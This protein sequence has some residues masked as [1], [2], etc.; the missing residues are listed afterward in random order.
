VTLSYLPS[1]LFVLALVTVVPL[2][3]AA[4][5]RM[6]LDDDRLRVPRA[7]LYRDVVASQWILAVIALAVLIPVV[8][9]LA[10]TGLSA[11]AGVGFATV[12]LLLTV[13][14]VLEGSG[15]RPRL[16]LRE[17]G[18]SLARVSFLL[19]RTRAERWWW[20][21]LSVTAGVCEE[22]VFRGFLL[23]YLATHAPQIGITGAVVLSS[24]AF[25]LGHLYQGLRSAALTALVGAA[26]AAAYLVTGS[27]WTPIVLHALLDLRILWIR[28]P[29]E[30]VREAGGGVASEVP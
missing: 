5:L 3:S 10:A 9:P 14:A 20:I 23:H 27:L 21:A 4:A 12:L 6:L 22:I 16:P 17:P 25:G 13:A 11:A 7:A 26:L 19:P 1:H 8:N 15:V 18:G 29:P 2:S 24:I 28:L 30:P